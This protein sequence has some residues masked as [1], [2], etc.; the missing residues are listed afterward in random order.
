M[1]LIGFA[2]TVVLVTAS[3]ALA[4]GP[5]FV[6]TFT[7]GSRSGIKSGILFAVAHTVVEFSLVMLLALGL[8]TVAN[9]PVVRI[10]IGVA[11]GCVLL[12]FGLVQIRNAMARSQDISQSMLPSKRRLFVIGLAFSALNPYFIMWW[13]TV[14]AQLIL[15]ALEFALFAGVVFMY[16]CHVWMDYVWLGAVSYFAKR[17]KNIMGSKY[18]RPVLGVFGVVLVYFGVLFLWGAFQV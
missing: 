14:G 5:L 11:G 12:I 17:G 4:P 1:D 9:Q 2:V 13:L 10:G 18:Y 6:A 15:L 8:L 16:V 7:H 3:G